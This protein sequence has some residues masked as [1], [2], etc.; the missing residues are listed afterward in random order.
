MGSASYAASAA[1]GSSY[2]GSPAFKAMY[3]GSGSGR[4]GSASYGGRAAS[5]SSYEGS[6]AFKAMY[7]DSG[8]SKAQITQ[9]GARLEA[10]CV[11]IQQ[12]IAREEKAEA[13]AQRRAEAMDKLREYNA[14]CEAEDAQRALAAEQAREAQRARAAEQA[15]E[16]Q[17][18]RAA[19]QAREAERARA[20]EQAPKREMILGRDGKWHPAES[21]VG[22][23]VLR[24][25]R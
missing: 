2:E 4:M 10:T 25:F 14:K 13:K 17:R 3:G 7:R 23:I 6:P 11:A 19:E 9:L 24:Q 16:A 5:G 15:R 21:F 12:R 8:P 18:A 20:A 22:E 1:S